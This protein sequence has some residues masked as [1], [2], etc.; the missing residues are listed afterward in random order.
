MASNTDIMLR[1]Q[2]HLHDALCEARAASI[3]LAA[4]PLDDLPERNGVGVSITAAIH[5]LT[6]SINTIATRVTND[7]QMPK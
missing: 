2:A 3:L 7:Q 1:A 4:I 6:T 5:R